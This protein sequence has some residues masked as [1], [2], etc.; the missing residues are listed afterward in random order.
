MPGDSIW[1]AAAWIGAT[2]TDAGVW[3]NP[4]GAAAAVPWC[5]G[6]PNNRDGTERCSNLLTSCTGGSDALAND[7]ECSKKV[8]VMCAVASTD[9]AGGRPPYAGLRLPYMLPVIRRASHG[10]LPM[11]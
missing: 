3:V 10:A 11:L 2:Q 5:S 9:C 8:R 1:T 7:F 6:E 4:G